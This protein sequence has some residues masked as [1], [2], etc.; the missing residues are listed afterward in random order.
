MNGNRNGTDV[1][2]VLQKK[3][4]LK[5]TKPKS[6]DYS[7]SA[8]PMV[9]EPGVPSIGVAEWFEQSPDEA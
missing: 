6:L 5:E 4:E 3:K 1:K 9:E 8:S 2:D 7:L